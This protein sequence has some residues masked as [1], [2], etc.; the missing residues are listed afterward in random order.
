[1]DPADDR[2]CRH[3]ALRRLCPRR[4]GD[5]V[6]QPALQTLN[7]TLAARDDRRRPAG[8]G[9]GDGLHGEDALKKA[10]PVGVS[11]AAVFSF[12]GSA[13]PAQLTDWVFQGNT[14]RTIVDITFPADTA[15][16]ATV[17][18]T[19]FWFNNRKQSGPAT[20]P[21]SANLPGGS[22]SMAA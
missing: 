10:K 18:V 2:P 9:V 5:E 16:G 22:V 19:A 4:I 21:K 1:V 8:D 20:D 3:S 11:G 13:P 17:W 12:I 6:H 14:S 7:G 15:N